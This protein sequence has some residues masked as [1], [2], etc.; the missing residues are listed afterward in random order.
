[1]KDH[2]H[3]GNR[4]WHDRFDTRVPASLVSKVVAVLMW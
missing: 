1:M 3:D 2:D 4:R